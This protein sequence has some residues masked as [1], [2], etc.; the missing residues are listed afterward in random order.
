[1]R[2]VCNNL[3]VKHERRRGGITVGKVK[4]FHKNA[5]VALLLVA[6]LIMVGGCGSHN[7]NTPVEGAK[8]FVEAMVN[9]DAELMKY[10]N[11]SDIFY[12]PQYCLQLATECNWA[13][14]DLDEIKYKDMGNGKVEVTFPDGNKL[15]LEMVKEN[16]KW[17]F[18]N[19]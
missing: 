5:A 2:K 10:I 7:N 11:H 18:Y 19:M 4:L 1:M 13:Q 12:P 16:D 8:L 9:S 17:Y 14:Y 3:K 6:V 15:T